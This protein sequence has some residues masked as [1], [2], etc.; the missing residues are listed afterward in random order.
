MMS[1]YILVIL[2]MAA[3]FYICGRATGI[4]ESVTV[5][6]KERVQVTRFFVIIA[7]LPLIYWTATRSL[8]FADTGSYHL[9]FQKLPTSLGMIRS[10]LEGVNKDKGFFALSIFLKILFRGHV[11]LYLGAIAAIHAGILGFVFRKYSVAF[12]T[13]LFI[14]VASTDYISWMHNGIRQFTAVVL[15]FAASKFL[16]EKKYVPLVLIILL[17]STIHLSALMM[18]PIVFIVQGEP[19]KIRIILLIIAALLIIYY[20]DSATSWLEDA[21]ADTQY[22]NVVTEWVE[23][24]DDGTNPLRVLV[25]AMPTILSL[26]GLRQIREAAD[27]VVNISCNMGIIATMLYL[28]SMV[29]SGIYI[30]RLPI[31]CS[32]Y[33]SCILL[34]WEIKHVFSEES[35]KIVNVIMVL[36]FLVFYYYQMHVAW[37]VF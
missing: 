33:S 6:G 4:H 1:Q 2:W 18:L 8:R 9:A 30:G 24:G 10:Y 19:W 35:G 5:N 3:L 29:T 12:A 32:L 27:P 31:Y 21:L 13:S 25:Y 22:A 34:P 16:F 11:R 14:F 15:I 23:G 7:I 36:A 37:G 20:V 26:I 17:A 28:I